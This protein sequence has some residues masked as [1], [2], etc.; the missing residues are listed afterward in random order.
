MTTGSRSSRC[1]WKVHCWKH[2]T[3]W[4]DRTVAENGTRN[5]VSEIVLRPI[6][7]QPAALYA[8]PTSLMTFP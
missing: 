6:K 4:V 2:Q 3:W 8:V 1:H 5:R 7:R